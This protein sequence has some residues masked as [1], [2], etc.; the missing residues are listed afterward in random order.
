MRAT[1][2]AHIDVRSD[3]I[4]GETRSMAIRKAERAKDAFLKEVRPNSG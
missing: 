4:D 3:G 1:L 2:G